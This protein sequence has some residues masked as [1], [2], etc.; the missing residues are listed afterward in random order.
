MEGDAERRGEGVF[1]ASVGEINRAGSER[2]F[3]QAVVRRSRISVTHID[4]QADSA[5]TVEFQASTV[6]ESGAI[7]HVKCFGGSARR[8]HCAYRG[9][10]PGDAGSDGEEGTPFRFARREIEEAVDGQIV[11]ACGDAVDVDGGVVLQGGS[12]VVAADVE[13]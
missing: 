4:T 7:T 10:V 3:R 1:G 8:L 13:G 11:V 12:Q 9:T 5:P 2:V 6:D